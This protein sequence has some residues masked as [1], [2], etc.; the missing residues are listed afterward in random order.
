MSKHT[1][2]PWVAKDDGVGPYIMAGE[3]DIA[4]AVGPFSYDYMEL[5]VNANALLIAAAP[6][7]LEML[8]RAVRRL[9]I[10]HANGDTIMR[11]WIIDARAVIAKVEGRSCS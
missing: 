3:I 9:E 6:D 1:P 11:E 4:M 7:L 5:E 8:D 2:G 10:A